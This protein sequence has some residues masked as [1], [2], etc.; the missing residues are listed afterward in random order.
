[1]K[2]CGNILGKWKLKQDSLVPIDTYWV[3]A[4]VRCSIWL[5]LTICRILLRSNTYGSSTCLSCGRFPPSDRHLWADLVA[6]SCFCK[7]AQMLTSDNSN[8][9][10]NKPNGIEIA[11]VD[12]KAK[13]LDNHIAIWFPPR[14]RGL[15]LSGVDPNL[16]FP[17]WRRAGWIFDS[18]VLGGKRSQDRQCIVLKTSQLKISRWMICSALNHAHILSLLWL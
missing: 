12:R 15:G 18:P 16:L 2:S 3:V 17:R 8:Q 6:R 11:Y 7:P 13:T 9:G 1:M 10:H 5:W 14:M 4:H